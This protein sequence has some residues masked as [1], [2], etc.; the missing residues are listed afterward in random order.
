MAQDEI[1]ELMQKNK[2]KEWKA[3]ELAN[4]LG[5]SVNSVKKGLLGLQVRGYVRCEIK[6]YHP[7]RKHVCGY[8]LLEEKQKL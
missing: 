3:R 7:R 1:L 8:W 5:I 4:H 6:C 2:D